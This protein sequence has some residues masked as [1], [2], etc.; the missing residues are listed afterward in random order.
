MIQSITNTFKITRKEF[1]FAIPKLWCVRF[2]N[3]QVYLPCAGENL[4]DSERRIC[5]V[6]YARTPEKLIELFR[7]YGIYDLIDDEKTMNYAR[8][9]QVS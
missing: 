2:S 5:T 7:D 6:H 9:I 8:K 3:I 1:C 4:T